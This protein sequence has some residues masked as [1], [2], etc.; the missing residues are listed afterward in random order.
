MK[1]IE[2]ALEEASI[3]IYYIS[4]ALITIKIYIR[5][6]SYLSNIVKIKLQLFKALLNNHEIH[7]LFRYLSRHIAQMPAYNLTSNRNH[8]VYLQIHRHTQILFLKSYFF[9]KLF[10]KFFF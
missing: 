3:D 6:L 1:D 2:H 4:P 10:H 7:L 8:I 9:K 5:E